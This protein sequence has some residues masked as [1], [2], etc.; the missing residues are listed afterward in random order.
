[1][2]ISSSTSSG[3]KH[4][5]NEFSRHLELPPSGRGSTLANDLRILAG[6]K[7]NSKNKEY[8]NDRLKEATGWIDALIANMATMS[9]MSDQELDE[10]AALRAKAKEATKPFKESTG[11]L[12]KTSVLAASVMYW[13]SFGPGKLVTNTVSGSLVAAGFPMAA[14]YAPWVN[15]MGVPSIQVAFAEPFGGAYR[16][17]GQSYQSP[18]G[19]AYANYQTA[20]ALMCRAWLEG[21][22]DDIDKYNAILGKIVDSV[23]EREQKAQQ[24]RGKPLYWTSGKDKPERDEKGLVKDPGNDP[25][26]WVMW[27]ARWRS[28]L[29]DEIPIH[30]FSA[31]NGFSGAASMVWPKFMAPALARIPDAGRRLSRWAVSATARRKPCAGAGASVPRRTNRPAHRPAG[32]ARR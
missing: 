28:F 21:K 12:R 31:L 9:D 24:A 11:A 30:T 29:S 19:A 14:T 23:I 3:H 25:A 15:A 1:M 8:I 4:A 7:M 6:K 2:H 10:V 26:F 20:L 32:D 27:Y 16:G 13:L 5:K 22:Q 17:D 18:D